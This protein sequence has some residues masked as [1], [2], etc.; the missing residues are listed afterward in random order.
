MRYTGQ[1]NSTAYTLASTAGNPEDGETHKKW[2]CNFN[3][4]RAIHLLLSKMMVLNPTRRPRSIQPPS[5]QDLGTRRQKMR[6]CWF[7]STVCLTANNISNALGIPPC[8]L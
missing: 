6:V 4:S 3:F 7:S 2:R 8:P 1:R 5:S